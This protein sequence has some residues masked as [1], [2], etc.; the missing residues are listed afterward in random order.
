[1]NLV[2]T[3]EAHTGHCTSAQWHPTE[4]FIASGGHDKNLV[5]TNAA[6]K[7]RVVTVPQRAK[8]YCV[9]WASPAGEW[10]V[11]AQVRPV[12]NFTRDDFDTNPKLFH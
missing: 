12:I 2:A 6:T 11:C 7:E 3:V 9:Q 1:M 5:I 8:V 4:P 10:E